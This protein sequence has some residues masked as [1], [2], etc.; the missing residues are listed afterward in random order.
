MQFQRGQK[1]KLSDLTGA[2]GTAADSTGAGRIEIGVSLTNPRHREIDVSCFGLDGQKQ[3]SDDRYFIYFNQTRSPCGSIEMVDRRGFDKVF[4]IDLSTLPAQVQR[5][6][7]TAN[8]DGDGAMSETDG[9]L[10]LLVD[11]VEVMRFPFSSDLFSAEKAVMIGEVYL[12]TV[13]RIAA[14]GQGFNGGLKA[15]LEH[16][17]GEAVAA[18]APA[19]T[20]APPPMPKPAPRPAPAPKAAPAPTPPPRKVSLGK[21]TLEKRGQKVSL[22]KGRAES[23][24]VIHVN[25]N[26]DSPKKSWFRDNSVDLD[27]GCMF[28]LTTGERGVIQPLGNQFGARARPPYIVLDKDDRSGAATDGENMRI[29]RPDLIRKLVIFAMI[30]EGTANFTTVNGRVTIKDG[31]GSEILV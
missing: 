7:F 31:R 10:A 15:L 29:Y 21:V 11:G 8:I 5:L 28:E 9:A 2:D 12:K 16:F 6:V 3:L 22:A 24:A 14:V 20:P 30:Y 17:G 25:L 1:S 4:Q 18:P 27:L 13:W 23:G 19:P 26:W